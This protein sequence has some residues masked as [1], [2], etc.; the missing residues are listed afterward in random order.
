MKRLVI[1]LR[2]G[3][4]VNVCADCLD[5]RKGFIMAWHGDILVAIVNAKETISCHISETKN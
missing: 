5:Y 3:T 2:D 1:K 4:Y